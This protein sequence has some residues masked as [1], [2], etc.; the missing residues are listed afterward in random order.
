MTRPVR[1]QFYRERHLIS[2]LQR[3]HPHMDMF[4]SKAKFQWCLNETTVA[5]SNILLH[6]MNN[7][8]NKGGLTYNSDRTRVTKRHTYGLHRRRIPAYNA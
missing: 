1:K 7:T 4:G 5:V 3:V 6:M 8:V 2:L